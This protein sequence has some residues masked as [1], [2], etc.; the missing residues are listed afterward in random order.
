[1]VNF[2]LVLVQYSQLDRVITQFFTLSNWLWYFLV[3]EDIESSS[4]RGKA[5]ATKG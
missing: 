1:M 4:L 2:K 5:I 3:D